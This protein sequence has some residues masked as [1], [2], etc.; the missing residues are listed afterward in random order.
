MKKTSYIVT[1][2]AVMATFSIS[3]MA[4][5]ANTNKNNIH[6]WPGQTSLKL[7]VINNASKT[8]TF[9]VHNSDGDELASKSCA[10]G[11]TCTIRSY[12]AYNPGGLYYINTKSGTS[13]SGGI[14]QT[15]GGVNKE[16]DLTSSKSFTKYNLII[17]FG[18]A[19]ANCTTSFQGK[20]GYNSYITD[21]I[22][23]GSVLLTVTAQYIYTG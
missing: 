20:A 17:Y 12:D 4:L 9:Y 19:N 15:Y 18:T 23:G 14:F 22:I 1:A 16:I 5:A 7:Q 8:K 2:V 6:M 13:T 21:N 10:S 11:S 3:G